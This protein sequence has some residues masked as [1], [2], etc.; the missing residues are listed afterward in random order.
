MYK[1]ELPFLNVI[2]GSS[3]LL[4]LFFHFFVFFF[5]AQEM[6]AGLINA[7]PLDLVEPA[8]LSYIEAIPFNLGHLGVA[9]FF[10]MS[11]FF[12]QPSLEKYNLIRP[13]LIH[14]FLR[15][16]PSYAFCFALGLVFVWG[17]AQLRDDIFPYSFDHIFSYFFWT[18]DIFGYEYIDGSVWSLEIQVKF[19]IFSALLWYLWRHRFLEVMT[20][21]LLFLCLVGYALKNYALQEDSSYHY[22]VYILNK[23]VKYSLLIA[24]GVCYYSYYSKKV[25]LLKFMILGLLLLGCFIS[26][27]SKYSIP[28]L[29]YSY[30]LGVFLFGCSLFFTNVGD[31]RNGYGSKVMGWF[32]N[33]S[34]PLYVGQVLPGYTIMYYMLE[35]DVNVYVA[36]FT[37]LAVVFPIAYFTHE[38]I[39]KVFSGIKVEASKHPK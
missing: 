19:Y 12:I 17:F 31:K 27:F 11:G 26:P 1:N 20:V 25:S 9:F 18:R 34:Y 37:A 15:L 4:V 16:W 6:S 8:Y 24:I 32:S 36:L 23:D 14:K 7:E 5:T 21:A 28:S 3:A 33:I 39:E 13:F 35:K 29:M 38:K 22:L 30:Y 10:L 2:R